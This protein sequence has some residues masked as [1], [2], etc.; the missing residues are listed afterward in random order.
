MFGTKKL[1][2]TVSD[3]VGEA[4]RKYKTSVSGASGSQ[5][6]SSVFLLESLSFYALQSLLSENIRSLVVGAIPADRVGVMFCSQQ[7]HSFPGLG[8]G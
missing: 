6:V 5:I 8:T 1:T 7:S 4:R 2:C 3:I